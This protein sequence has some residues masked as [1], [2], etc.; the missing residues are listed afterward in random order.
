MF[1][2]DLHNN[3]QAIRDERAEVIQAHQGDGDAHVVFGAQLDDGVLLAQ[4]DVL[5]YLATHKAFNGVRQHDGNAKKDPR[6][7]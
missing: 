5:K 3:A 4:K 6:S 7:K 1:Y 2:I